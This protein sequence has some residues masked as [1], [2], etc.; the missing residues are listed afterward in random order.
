VAG[1]AEW[2]NNA[3]EPETLDYNLGDTV[4]DPYREG[5]YRASD[6]DPVV[7]SLNLTAPTADVTASVKIVR[8]GVTLNRATGKYSANVTLTNTGSTALA[9][10]LN[11][12][13][14]GLTAG[15]TLDNKSGEQG[16]APYLTLPGGGLAPGAS[17][18]VT[19]VFVN[20][21]KV[22]INYTAKL[23]SGTN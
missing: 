8:G 11:L 17:V 16:G 9:G 5:A 23:I 2:H 6:H 15:V 19:T 20:P 13:L 1:A 3:D 12:R 22:A 18:V 4:Q 21:A 7:V 14:D 10:P